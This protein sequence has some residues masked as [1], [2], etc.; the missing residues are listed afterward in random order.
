MALGIIYVSIIGIISLSEPGLIPG[1]ILLS[2]YVV[3]PIVQL[4]LYRNFPEANSD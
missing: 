4:I 2:A 3:F 1:I